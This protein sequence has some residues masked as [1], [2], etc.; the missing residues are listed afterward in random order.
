MSKGILKTAATALAFAAMTLGFCACGGAGKPQEL[1]APGPA[2][3]RPTFAEKIVIG[4]VPSGNVID[5]L[6]KMGPLRDLMESELGVEIDVKFAAD[7]ADFTRAMIENK[8]DLAFCAP[9]QYIEAHEKAGYEAALRP[10]RYGSDTYAGVIVTANPKITSISQL[11]GKKIAFADRNST[12]GFIFPL[13]LLAAN[14]IKMTDF[15]YEFLIGHDNVV[16]NVE[17]GNYDAGACF[18]GADVRY[19]SNPDVNLRVLAKTDPIFNEPIAVSARF[20]EERGEL[21]ARAI[22]LLAKLHESPQGA[23]AL[24]AMPDGVSRFVPAADGDYDSVR[25]YKANLPQEVVEGKGI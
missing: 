11:K 15:Q 4:R 5:I 13:G 14:G 24:K 1:A 25:R 7:Y 12:S 17:K 2:P 10:I 8:F 22:A 16:L 18:E 19:R 6:E 9:F 21:A 23:A 20:K 3:T